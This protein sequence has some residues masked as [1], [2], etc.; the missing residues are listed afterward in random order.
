MNLPP[1]TAN[2]DAWKEAVRK[3]VGDHMFAHENSAGHSLL[4]VLLNSLLRQH[5]ERPEFSSVPPPL[6]GLPPMPLDHRWVELR[7]VADP[8]NNPTSAFERTRQAVGIHP[9]HLSVQR[10]LNTGESLIV[11]GPP[12]CGKT[13]ILKWAA[14]YLMRET[15]SA[16]LIPLYVPLRDYVRWR[17]RHPEVGHPIYRYLAA[18]HGFRSGEAE[19]AFLNFLLDVEGGPTR[20]RRLCLVLLDGWDEVRD[21]ERADLRSEL[22]RFHFFLPAIL[23]SRPSGFVRRL[24]ITAVYEVSPL[25]FDAMRSLIREWFLRI[26]KPE[27]ESLL[28]DHLDRH[29]SLREMARNPFVLTLLCAVVAHYQISVDPLPLP[30]TR[31]E[32]YEQAVNLFAEYCDKE[33]GESGYPFS[34]ETLR[35]TEAAA[36]SLLGRVPSPYEFDA[37]ALTHATDGD[38]SLQGILERARLITLVRERDRTFTF[39]HA[40][41]HEYLAAQELRRQMESNTTELQALL[42]SPIWLQVLQFAFAQ[43]RGNDKLS[44]LWE[45]LKKVLAHPDR[46]G[47]LWLQAGRLLTDVNVTDGGQK[48]LGSDIRERIWDLLCRSPDARPYVDVLVELDTDY[49]IS[50]TQSWTEGD[51]DRLALLMLLHQRVSP[52]HPRR[53]ELVMRAAAMHLRTGVADGTE[54]RETS[55]PGSLAGYFGFEPIGAVNLRDA[56]ETRTPQEI[57]AA[58]SGIEPSTPTRIRA[59]RMRLAL[60][61]TEEAE[62][63]LTDALKSAVRTEDAIEL[64]EALATLGTLAA[65]DVL[66]ATLPRFSEHAAVSISLLQALYDMPMDKTSASLVLEYLKPLHPS[67]VRVVAAQAL[68]RCIEAGPLNWLAD[69]ARLDE[70]DASLRTAAL[71][72]LTRAGA[73]SAVKQLYQEGLSSRDGE[74]RRTAWRYLHSIVRHTQPDYDHGRVLPLIRV[75]VKQ[76]LA[77]GY[78]ASPEVIAWTFLLEQSGITGETMA[79]VYRI[80]EDREAS[81]LQR[82]AACRSIH[83]LGDE[84][85]TP[86]LAEVLNETIDDADLQ[87]LAKEAA[88]ALAIRAPQMLTRRSEPLIDQALWKMSL[89]TGKL[90]FE[91]KIVDPETTAQRKTPVMNR[92]FEVVPPPTDLRFR[93]TEKLTRTEVGAIWFDL[94]GTNMDE[95]MSGRAKSDCVIEMLSRVNQRMMTAALIRILT[96]HYPRVLEN[97]LPENETTHLRE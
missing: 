83:S 1:L 11:T 12:G 4:D 39:L 33:F 50:Q 10:L 27:W 81:V 31:A 59:Y 45:S 43:E 74:E 18:Q 64:A 80:L 38:S 63:F 2:T 36:L 34:H 94:F 32:L 15:R 29:L 51:A 88:N 85:D 46:Y 86:I 41:I 53:S 54:I 28:V 68:G 20:L 97:A 79:M 35:R 61:R 48:L 17:K 60:S 14:L 16:S 87:E 91:N 13:T 72:A 55:M 70:Q 62:A 77:R 76:E 26:N 37:S 78:D 73:V 44:G 89:N 92:V 3:R 52:Q 95:D 56:D 49:A 66:I 71:E 23:T 84:R 24:P 67:A 47:L 6:P 96:R 25:S 69:Y 65:R 75:L 9:A 82:I 7:V 40:T 8:A 93:M 90:F 57:I 58:L 30:L 5:R 22:E 19:D 21:A 42:S